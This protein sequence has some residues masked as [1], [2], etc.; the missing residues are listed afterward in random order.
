M[1]P[2]FILSLLMGSFFCRSFSVVLFPLGFFFLSFFFLMA[3]FFCR[4]FQASASCP[5]HAKWGKI[6]RRGKWPA[7][8]TSAGHEMVFIR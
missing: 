8:A 4:S 3:S 7:R 1:R 2:S 5:S 6:S